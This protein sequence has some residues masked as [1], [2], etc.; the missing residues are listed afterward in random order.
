[1][2]VNDSECVTGWDSSAWVLGA[3]TAAEAVRLLSAVREDFTYLMY[4]G[5]GCYRGHKQH[6]GNILAGRVAAEANGA[7]VSSK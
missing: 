3:A 6:P 7:A 5:L 4:Q 2:P 1:M